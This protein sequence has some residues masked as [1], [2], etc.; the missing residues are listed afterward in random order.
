MTLPVDSVAPGVKKTGLMDDVVDAFI[1]PSALFDRVRDSSFV[2]PAVIQ[3]VL[4][5]VLVFALRNLISP[6]FD[7]E[8]ARGMAKASA[9][10]AAQGREMPA[11]A[12]EMSRKIASFS[13]MFG[14]LLVPW[15]IAIF[16][17]LATWIGA[18]IVGAKISYGQ[19]AT[20]ASWSYMP[21]VLGF[22]A[23]AVQGALV[24]TNAIRGASDGQLGPAR[25]L[26]PNTASPQ[27]LALLQ[28]L[29]VFGIWSLILTAIG[30]AV[31]ARTSRSTGAL[32]AVIRFAIGALL[33]LIP[34]LMSRS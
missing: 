5:G 34:T 15:F 6:Y 29:D 10:A 2:R 19:S 17:G 21:G 12:I 27:L 13:T 30:V 32:A 33:T 25:F 16:G 26:D 23:L 31:V 1:H 8:F 20:I 22:V 11:S 3:M 18:R 14:P 4:C 9:Q 28:N 24:D 7:A